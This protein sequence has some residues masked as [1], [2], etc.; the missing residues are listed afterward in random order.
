MKVTWPEHG[1]E[2]LLWPPGVCWE[3]G[4]SWKHWTWIP[5]QAHV[6]WA[7]WMNSWD[8]KL[9]YSSSRHDEAD[10]GLIFAAL[11]KHTQL[12]TCTRAIIINNQFTHQC[13]HKIIFFFFRNYYKG[14][15]KWFSEYSS[16]YRK[17]YHVH[18]SVACVLLAKS[19][20]LAL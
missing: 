10:S 7:R 4:I 16:D 15:V 14:K 8:W 12:S 19:C 3:P 2:K 1:G 18:F 9:Y 13:H 20:C 6:Q 17:K 5:I 11:P